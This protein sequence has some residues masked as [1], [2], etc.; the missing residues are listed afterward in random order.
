MGK[1]SRSVGMRSGVDGIRRR[2][3]IEDHTGD[4]VKDKDTVCRDQLCYWKHYSTHWKSCQLG[5]T[6]SL[7]RGDVCSVGWGGISAFLFKRGKA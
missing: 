4:G 5:H 2:K 7:R 3:G 6:N 1:K